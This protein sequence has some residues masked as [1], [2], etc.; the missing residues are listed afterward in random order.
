M[1]KTELISAAAE[2]SGVTK[3][4]TEKALNAALELIATHLSRGEKIQ[5]SGFGNF[6]VR[7]REARGGRNPHTGEAVSIP[8]AKVPVFKPSKLLKDSVEK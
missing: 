3:K 1:N 2:R 4:D 5:L 6:E 7:Q 8:A